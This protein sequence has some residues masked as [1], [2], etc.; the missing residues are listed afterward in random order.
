MNQWLQNAID[1]VKSINPNLLPSPPP[2]IEITGNDICF[3]GPSGEIDGQDVVL[4]K[5]LPDGKR[6]IVA[7]W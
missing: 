1:F 3:L 7:S 5:D 4:C 2:T 6:A